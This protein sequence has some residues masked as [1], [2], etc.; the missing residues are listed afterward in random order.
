MANACPEI[1]DLDLAEAFSLAITMEDEGYKFYDGVLQKLENQRA[2]NE[3]AYLRDEELKHKN[4]FT[5][6]LKDSGNEFVKNEESDLHCWVNDQIITP[7]QEALE[8]MEPRSAQQALQMGV[9]L[10]SM[11]ID[12]FERLKKIVKDKESAKAIKEVLKVEKK[13]KKLLTI[14]MAY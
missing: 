10:E 12:M 6:L 3:L 8:K 1:T 14:I 5:K 13:H 7:M 9:Q 11:A 2:K 4:L